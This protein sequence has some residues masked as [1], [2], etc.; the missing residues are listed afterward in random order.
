MDLPK[1]EEKLAAFIEKSTSRG[2][3]TENAKMIAKAW[4]KEGLKPRCI[5]RD[6][7][8]GTPCPL[9]GFTDKV[10]YVWFDAPIGYLSITANYTKEWEKWWKNPQ[11]VELYN[12]M[13]KDNVPFHSIIFPSTLIG[14]EDD[15]TLV[16]HL[17]ATEYLNYEEGKFSKSRGVGVFGTDVQATGIPSDY[18]R[19]YL[20]YIRPE[21]SDATFNWDDFAAKV[22]SELLANIGNFINRALAMCSKNWEG[23][24]PEIDGLIERDI[25]ALAQIEAEVGNYIDSLEKVKLKDGIHSILAISRIGNQFMQINEPWKLLK[26]L[27][28]PILIIFLTYFF[29]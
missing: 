8:W 11:Q 24:V 18:W 22:N 13:A 29:L 2:D 12:F 23:V 6:L 19:F 14:T 16:N 28:V 9:E 17:C 10:F 1:V 26:G 25:E 7:K 21:G 15:Y 3:W 5:T 20:L 4:L 27:L